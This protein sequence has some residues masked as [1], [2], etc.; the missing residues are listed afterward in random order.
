MTSHMGTATVAGDDED[1]DDS[2]SDA[3]SG[4]ELSEE[5]M[6]WDDMEK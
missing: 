2:D 3:S 5:G 6:S 1:E 4:E